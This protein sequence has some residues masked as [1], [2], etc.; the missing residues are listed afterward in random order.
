MG[1][2]VLI[3]NA[4]KL[5][6]ASRT[7]IQRFVPFP[8]VGGFQRVAGQLVL[9]FTLHKLP[10]S[11]SAATANICNVALMRHSEL[12]EGIDVMDDNGNV[13]GSSKVAARHVS[14]LS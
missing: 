6:P 14:T 13:V 7:I 8:A 10:F 11:E 3:K 9:T 12:S 1:L 4:N 5:S 2:N